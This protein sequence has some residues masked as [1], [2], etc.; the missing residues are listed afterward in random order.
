MTRIDLDRKKRRRI[1]KTY[2]YST[3]V[4][5]A[6]QRKLG[7]LDRYQQQFWR[8]Y[9]PQRISKKHRKMILALRLTSIVS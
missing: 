7:I 2:C 4:E 9:G 6:L 5:T 1:L 3:L 8:L